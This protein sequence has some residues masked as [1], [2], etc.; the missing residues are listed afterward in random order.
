MLNNNES[1]LL[2]RYRESGDR[3]ALGILFKQYLPLVYGVCL[4]YLKNKEKAQDVVSEVFE[5]LLPLLREKEIR[6]FKS[7]VYVVAK[8]QSLGQLRSQ[9]IWVE[10][11]ELHDQH[12]EE[13]QQDQ[14]ILKEAQLDQL[15][16]A[17]KE[18]KPD[19]QQSLDL[20]YLQDYSYQEVADQMKLDLKKVKSL[21][22][23]GK[24][25][26]RIRLTERMNDGN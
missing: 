16:E 26:L 6:D 9:R 7:F 4:K 23:N 1:E 19:Q 5:K 22:Q 14:R 11:Q 24:R 8:N 20:F 10:Y 15:K 2:A 12:E 17:L 25:M 3:M 13:S 21:I 18:L